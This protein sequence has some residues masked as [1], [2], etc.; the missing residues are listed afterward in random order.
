[1]GIKIFKKSSGNLPS[2]DK[3]IT[4]EAQK[5]VP[6]N[7]SPYGAYFVMGGTLVG[8]GI[9]AAFG[10]AASIWMPQKSAAMVAEEK[11]FKQEMMDKLPPSKKPQ[12]TQPYSIPGVLVR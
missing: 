9:A 10:V 2:D 1:M 11:A 4:E 12:K 7:P 8:I 3:A 6:E 5:T